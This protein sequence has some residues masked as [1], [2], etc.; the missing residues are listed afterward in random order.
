MAML[1]MVQALNLALREALQEDPTTVIFGQDVGQDEGVFRVT[2]GLYRDFGAA[3]VADMPVA[4]S[5]IAGVAVGMCLNGMRPIAEMQFSGFGY[6]A[7]HQI[8]NHLSRFRT[9]TRGRFSMPAVVRMPYAAGIRAIE[10]H[11]ESR[12]TIWAH[13]PGLKMVIPS[14]PRNARALL[15]AAIWDPDPVIFYEPKSIYRAFKE[16]VPEAPEEMEIGKA[17]VARSGADVTL[18]AYGAMMRPALE[19]AEELADEHSIDA[20]VVDVLTISP[21]DTATICASV[22]KTGRAV[23]IHE[24]PRTLG[25]AAEIAARLAENSLM[26][27]EAPLRRVTGYDVIMPFFA[28]EKYFIPDV[29]RVVAAAREVVAF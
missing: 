5:C 17:R 14:G 25:P 6:H 15:R 24:A 1:T 8:E 11:S 3:R 23:L 2:E 26:Y 18:I 9:R 20:E 29:R 19:A 13:L 7:F 4:E 21:M 16:E 22:E 28:T 27:L 12:E 10:H